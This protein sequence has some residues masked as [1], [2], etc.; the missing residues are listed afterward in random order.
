MRVRLAVRRGLVYLLPLAI[1]IV[2]VIVRITAS[3]LLERLSLFCFDI[4]QKAAPREAGDTP[5]RIVDIDDPSLNEIGQWPWPRTVVAQLVDRLRDAGAAVIAFDID[6]AEPDRTAPK[7]LLPMLAQN[8]VGAE[9]TDRLV[10]ALPDPDRRLAEAM[11]DVPVVT[12]FILSDHGETRP[13]L[14]KAGFAFAGN[15]PLGHVDTFPAAVANLPEFEAAAVGNGFL[16]QS[17]DWDHVV[18]RVPLLMRLGEKPYPSL[19]AE[20]LRVA[21]GATTYVGRAAGASAEKSFGEKTGL[22]AIR[23]G[24]LTIPT[25]PV[26]RVWLHY[27]VPRPDR[28]VP[29]ADVLSGKFDPALFKDNFVL[30]GT[31]ASGV[32]NDLQATPIAPDVPGVEIHAQLLEQIFQGGYLVRPDWAVGAEILFAL[33]VGLGLIVGLP[34]IGAL[35]SAVLGG[36]SV[37]VAFGTSWFAFKYAQ[38]L[39]DPV[40]PWAVITLVYLVGSLLGY[41]RTEAQQREIRGAF[42]HY[43]SPH[44]VAELAAHPEKLKLGGEARIMTIMF[45]DIR[46]FTSLSEKLDAASLTQ[47]MNSFLTPMTEIITERKGTIDKYIGDCIMAF[48]NAPLDDP[49]HVENAVQA[50]Q[51]MRRKLVELN[52]LW[53]E[54][55]AYRVFLPVRVGIGINTGECVVGNFGSMQHFDYSLLGDPVNLASRLEGLGKVYGIDLV[56][57]EETAARFADPALIEVDLVAVKGKSEA[58]RIYTLPPESVVEEQFIDR[59]SALLGAYRRQDWASAL[60]LLDDGRLAAARFLAPVYDLYRRRIAQFQIEGPPTDWNGV[61]TAEEK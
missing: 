47:F 25:D 23:I 44:F 10:A 7:M 3:D 38:Q 11:G 37:A 36:A 61:F 57:G 51:A 52:R 34:R 18:R 48:W 46:G 39:L 14:A 9:E 43:M 17:V 19:A 58:G 45:S 32:I 6:F 59:H 28:L 16:N 21:L 24:Q 40:Y 56:I 15:D 13:P 49:D 22:T 41:L 54:Q 4:Y 8:G 27:A 20:V 30:V 12:G 35:P 53:Q 60:R 31:S 1:L 2:A 26:G 29:A 5:I 55:P 33:L 50:A 42:S